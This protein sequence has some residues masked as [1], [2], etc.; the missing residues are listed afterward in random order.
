MPR[1]TFA[2]GAGLTRKSSL[3]SKQGTSFAG[4][5]P[6][7]G[8]AGITKS[9]RL[10]GPGG[11]TNK[12]TIFYMNQVGGIGRGRSRKCGG[13]PCSVLR[14]SQP[15]TIE[16]V[17]DDPLDDDPLDD[18]SQDDS[19]DD[20]LDD[21]SHDDPLDDDS[22]DDSHDDSHDDSDSL[23]DILHK[24]L[25]Q[26]LDE[27]MF[28]LADI[29]DFIY[30][31]L[32]LDDILNL[33]IAVD[34]KNKKLHHSLKSACLCSD[35]CNTKAIVHQ[36]GNDTYIHEKGYKFSLCITEII[37]HASLPGP[38]TVS[39]NFLLKDPIDLD[40]DGDGTEREQLD[41]KN[42]LDQINSNLSEF[43]HGHIQLEVREAINSILKNDTD[44]A[45]LA[46]FNKLK[47]HHLDLELSPYACHH[48]CRSENSIMIDKYTGADIN[49]LNHIF[50]KCI[51]ININ[52]NNLYIHLYELVK[53]KPF[54]DLD[55]DDS[56]D[57]SIEEIEG[58]IIDKD[59]TEEVVAV[60]DKDGDGKITLDE[61][62]PADV[63]VDGK[64]HEIEILIAADNDVRIKF[65]AKKLAKVTHMKVCL[66]EQ[67]LKNLH[68]AGDLDLLH[69]KLT[70]ISDAYALGNKPNLT[71]INLGKYIS[72]EDKVTISIETSSEDFDICFYLK[73]A[74]THKMLQDKLHKC[75]YDDVASMIH[76][77]IESFEANE[78]GMFMLHCENSETS[79]CSL[80]SNPE[81]LHLDIK[82]T[83]HHKNEVICLTNASCLGVSDIQLGNLLDE[84]DNQVYQCGVDNIEN[85]EYILYHYNNAYHL[86]LV[87]CALH[88]KDCIDFKLICKKDLMALLTST[89]NQLDS[90]EIEA[91]YH[92][93]L[94]I[95]KEIINNMTKT[96]CSKYSIDLNTMIIHPLE[97]PVDD[98]NTLH[99]RY[100]ICGMT[101]SLD[102][103]HDIHNRVDIANGSSNLQY[104]N[105]YNYTST[106]LYSVTITSNGDHM[107]TSTQQV[108]DSIANRTLYYTTL[109]N[110][111][112]PEHLQSTS[113]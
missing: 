66:A 107:H 60:L 45:L 29:N 42:I 22:Q 108:L 102:Y 6:G 26:H 20:P 84:N 58:Q 3:N 106:L 96:S 50:T 52:N 103:V 43:D 78:I 100:N 13:P 32:L 80:V 18:D 83:K 74:S 105:S 88:E 46:N 98:Y 113:V 110:S 21:D 82:Y 87:E 39:I 41:F 65:L 25:R 94:T 77:K 12:K 90:S 111:I 19:H 34:T 89:F 86:I 37:E 61:Y 59:Y 85:S 30:E 35:H 71:M 56:G 7:L 92:E 75:L 70:N 67:Y 27:D 73:V 64:L 53:E 93:V 11:G 10:V 63:E 28:S 76:T 4:L 40:G 47:L 24:K 101:N 79:Y 8:R 48:V 16:Y 5:R 33:C 44:A 36:D 68:A 104:Y 9:M 2:A 38:M 23:H 69:S 91:I 17:K 31:L 72:S 14:Y 109:N 15:T 95:N 57:L 49:E 54:R 97:D 99:S 112:N 55:V 1:A 51:T 62:K 81:S